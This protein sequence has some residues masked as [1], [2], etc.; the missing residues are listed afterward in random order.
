MTTRTRCGSLKTEAFFA[1]S[2]CK[3]HRGGQQNEYGTRFNTGDYMVA[4]QWYERLTE[5]G[6]GRQREF[7]RGERAIDVGS[8]FG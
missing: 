7:V 2:C 6:S 8:G 4:V 1:G 5:S 3:H